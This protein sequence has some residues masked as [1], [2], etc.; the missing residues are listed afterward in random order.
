M[1]KEYTTKPCTILACCIEKEGTV[2]K[3]DDKFVYECKGKGAVR[4]KLT[5]TATTKPKVG[6]YIIQLDKE[7]I[8][9]C[10]REVFLKKY[11]VKGMVIK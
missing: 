4:T 9:L 8:Y 7:D 10:K 2:T 5:F 1:I 11:K 3:K 6:D